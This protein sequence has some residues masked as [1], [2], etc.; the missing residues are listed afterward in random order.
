MS[1]VD[2]LRRLDR[3]QRSHHLKDEEEATCTKVY[4]AS[5]THSQLTQVLPELQRLKLL[6]SV[7][8]TDRHKPAVEDVPIPR[9]R[10]ASQRDALEPYADLE[11]CSK[12]IRTVSLGSR[13]QLCINDELK[14]KTQDLDEACRELLGGAYENCLR[15]RHSSTCVLEKEDKRCPYLPPPGEEVA[16]LD[17]R[18]QI[19]ASPHQNLQLV[20][21]LNAPSGISEGH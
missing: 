6:N 14:A 7:Q 13:K 17:F 16:M 19:L 9:K 12:Q 15:V 8:V 10:N 3:V 4:Y 20:K 1:R 18:D 5:R 21:L 11:N 2:H